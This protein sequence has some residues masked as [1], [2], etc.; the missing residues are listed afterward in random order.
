MLDVDLQL[1]IHLRAR[2]MLVCSYLS[3]CMLDGRLKLS[4]HMLA[5]CWSAVAIGPRAGI[6]LVNFIHLQ[7]DYC[8]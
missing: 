2:W 7:V 4:I 8:M 1:S 6:C 3:I 5:G